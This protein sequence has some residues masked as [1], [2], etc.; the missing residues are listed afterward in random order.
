MD[1]FT[2]W[3]ANQPRYFKL[4]SGAFQ[5]NILV[6]SL[7]LLHLSLLSEMHM[8][9]FGWMLAQAVPPSVKN[10]NALCLGL[11]SVNGPRYHVPKAAFSSGL[12]LYRPT[13]GPLR[14]KWLCSPACHVPIHGSLLR[15]QTA[16][17]LHGLG[18][19]CTPKMCLNSNTGRPSTRLVQ[20]IRS[21]VMRIW[22]TQG[23]GSL[24]WS[25]AI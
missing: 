4:E 6:P 12:R 22:N 14:F 25:S 10:R 11:Q 20:E 16:E 17:T 15:Q 8:V 9:A 21:F 19:C 2:Y 3:F 18:F 7:S 1:S 23:Q 13:P 5:G 24:Q